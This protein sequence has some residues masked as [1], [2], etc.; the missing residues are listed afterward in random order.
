MLHLP[1]L[2]VED[3]RVCFIPEAKSGELQKDRHRIGQVVKNQREM[4]TRKVHSAAVGHVDAKNCGSTWAILPLTYPRNDSS[5]TDRRQRG[6]GWRCSGYD[7]LLCN[8]PPQNFG[9]HT[10]TTLFS[11]MILWVRNSGG[12][13]LRLRL[14]HVALTV[15][16]RWHTVGER[17]G[18]LTCWDSWITGL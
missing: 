8:K 12:T 1:S 2:P 15:V 4:G 13:P 6:R 9:L 11:V 10:A 14:L 17:A 3:G 5:T 18:P 16:S 7:L